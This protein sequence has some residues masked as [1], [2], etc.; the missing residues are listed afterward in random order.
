MCFVV[1]FFFICCYV[2][3]FAVVF[4]NYFMCFSGFFFLAFSVCFTVL[5]C[6]LVYSD[7]IINLW[8]GNAWEYQ[9]Y[10]GERAQLYYLRVN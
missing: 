9:I 6:L 3:M 2:F 10:L 8:S 1:F 5:C 4:L 7:Y